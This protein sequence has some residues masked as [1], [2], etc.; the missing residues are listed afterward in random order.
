MAINFPTW[1]TNQT[2]IPAAYLVPA[3]K[4]LYTLAACEYSRRLHNAGW[5]WIRGES[6]TAD[7][8]AI[9][10]A[11]FPALWPTPPTETQFRN[12]LENQWEPRQNEAHGTLA[13][14]R[15]RI[16][17]FDLSWVDWDSLI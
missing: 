14:S 15:Q 16:E 12:Y 9:L 4:L 3:K 2:A 5:K 10:Q 17:N 7:E 8:Q 13:A 6:L 1:V 11:E